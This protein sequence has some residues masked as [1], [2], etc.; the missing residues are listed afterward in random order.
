MGGQEYGANTIKTGGNGE[1]AQNV[2]DNLGGVGYVGL[3]YANAPGVKAVP[4]EGVTPDPANASTYP[5][6]RKLFYYTIAD[7]TSPEAMKF[8]KWSQS[9]TEAAAIITEVGFIPGK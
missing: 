7:K 4:I 5:L 1:I 8:I 2:A 6:S 3:S 9:S